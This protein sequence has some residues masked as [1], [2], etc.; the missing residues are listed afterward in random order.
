MKF[1][2]EYTDSPAFS[3]RKPQRFAFVGSI[4]FGIKLPVRE[5]QFTAETCAHVQT[6]LQKKMKA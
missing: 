5:R 3:D 2:N 6:V 4:A 1:P